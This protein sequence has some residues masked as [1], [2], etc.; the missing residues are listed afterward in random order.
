MKMWCVLAFFLLAAAALYFAFAPIPLRVLSSSMEPTL[1][2]PH[3]DLECPRCHN[4]VTLTVNI[5]SRGKIKSARFGSCPCCGFSE[6]P[7][8]PRKLVKG[9]RV[10]VDRYGCPEPRRWEVAALRLSDGS[11]AVK[12]VAGL[13][14][15]EVELRRG[16]LYVDGVPVPKPKA[17]WSRVFL[18]TV[19][20]AEPGRLLFLNRLPHPVLEGESP[21]AA[22]F[23]LAVTNTAS[24]PSLDEPASVEFVDD[25]A[26]E[27]PRSFLDKG[28]LIVNQ[29]DRAWLAERGAAPETLLLRRIPLP[30]E[31]GPEDAPKLTAADF[32]GAEPYSCGLSAGGKTAV[33]SCADGALTV[34][35][36]GKECG[37]Y[38]N[39]PISEKNLPVN[40]PLILLTENPREYIPARFL[41]FRDTGYGSIPPRRLGDDEYFLL[42][43]NPAVSVDSRT[44]GEPARR[45]DLRRIR[46]G[47][48]KETERN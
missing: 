43:D 31:S 1:Y 25:Y 4:P 9:D 18:N 32:D 12:R 20:K 45:R 30:E 7:L 14:G 13:P 38:P 26:I 48:K 17:R 19:R 23:P 44:S 11:L 2:G 22:P 24:A 10:F 16:A 35:L 21:D 36:D 41:L 33:L 34:W 39:P 3:W 46:G 27:F 29:G 42:G 15:E 40:C 47:V 28:A 37:S 5:G 6:I 8:N